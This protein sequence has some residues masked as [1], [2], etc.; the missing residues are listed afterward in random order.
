VSLLA[1][2]ACALP[3]CGRVSLDAMRRDYVALEYCRDAVTA[4]EGRPVNRAKALR[5]IDRALELSPRNATVLATAPSVYVSLGEYEKAWRS[6]QRLSMPDAVVTGQCLLRLGRAR[7]GLQML[8]AAVS[9]TRSLYKAGKLPESA[10]AMQMNNAG[11]VMADSGIG[12]DLADQYLGAAVGMLPMDFNCADSLG[13]LRYRQG[14]FREAVFLLE[15]AVRLQPK[16]GHPDLCYHLGAA[17]ARA[18]NRPRAVTLLR[19]ALA[20]DP[21]QPEAS[22]EL[23]RLNWHLPTLRLARAVPAPAHE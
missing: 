20:L 23:K 3:G 21:G 10:Y 14:R 11:Y 22:Q 4:L 8:G 15:R 1:L 12:L 5:S 18:G 7:D 16:P 17:Y 9:E 19:R 2:G 13:W 6:L